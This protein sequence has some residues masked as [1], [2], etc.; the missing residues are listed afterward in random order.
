[1]ILDDLLRQSNLTKYKLSKNSGVPYSTIEDI[2]N[3]KTE[4]RKTT[5]E[6]VYKISKALNIS[7][8]TLLEMDGGVLMDQRMDF[9]LYKSTIC[10]RVKDL[11]DIDFLLE[12]LRSGEI[13]TLYERKWYAESFYL[14]AMVDFLSRI[15]NI[16]MVTDYNDIRE[17]KLAEKIYP[18][19][20][21]I[22][23]KLRGDRTRFEL[24]EK[25]AIP[26]FKRFNIMESEVRDVI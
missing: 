7:M 8:K 5:A 26:E 21:W 25:Q 20:A 3:G 2:C 9:D 12:V 24:C 4:L 6:T 16:E 18:A 1:M 15:S 13:R 17:Q 19:S 14:L 10:H 23:Y 22:S 11:G